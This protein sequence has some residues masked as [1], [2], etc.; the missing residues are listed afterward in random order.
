[1]GPQLSVP[2]QGCALA[3]VLKDSSMEPM[4]ASGAALPQQVL[5]HCVLESSHRSC[6]RGTPSMV[7]SMDAI[8]RFRLSLQC[9]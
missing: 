7:C 8:A 2:Q 3:T 1:M 9:N 6:C 4:L 5:C